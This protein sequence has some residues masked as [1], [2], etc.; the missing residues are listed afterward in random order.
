M[1]G[2]FGAGKF[3]EL[4]KILVLVKLNLAKVNHDVHPLYLISFTVLEQQLSSLDV[5]SSIS[6]LDS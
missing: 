5:V 3:G 1:E 4:C 2:N 6:R